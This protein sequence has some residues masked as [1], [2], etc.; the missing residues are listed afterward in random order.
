MGFAVGN[1][2]LIARAGAREI[3]SRLRRLHADP[4]R[5]DAA[6]LNGPDDCVD[7]DARHLQE[8]ARRAGGELRAGRL[9]HSAAARDDVRLGASPGALS[10][11]GLRRIRQD[12]D[13]EGRRL[14]RF[15]AVSPGGAG[16]GFGERLSRL[17]KIFSPRWMPKILIRIALVE[18][19]QRIRAQKLTAKGWRQR[20]PKGRSILLAEKPRHGCKVKQAA[21]VVAWSAPQACPLMRSICAPQPESFFS[22]RSKPRSR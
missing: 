3:L 16:V 12:A 1:E 5:G 22:R 4:G 11:H 21:K 8:A 2:R 15:F 7:E 6:A 10:R 9:A 17:A 20:A 19:E 13:R 14:R 18:N